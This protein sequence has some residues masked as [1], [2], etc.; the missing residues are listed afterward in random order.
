MVKRRT[1]SRILPLGII[2]IFIVVIGI[3]MISTI[4]SE[5]QKDQKAWNEVLDADARTSAQA[6]AT[7]RLVDKLDKLQAQS[8]GNQQDIQT[9]KKDICESWPGFYRQQLDGQ[10]GVPP[11]QIMRKVLRRYIRGT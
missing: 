10:T 11:V 7:L 8:P 1:F 5:N 6:T 4:R 2:V 3:S 9:L